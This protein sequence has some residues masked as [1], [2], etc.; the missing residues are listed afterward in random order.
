MLFLLSE[1]EVRQISVPVKSG[2]HKLR[3]DDWLD[4]EGDEG[5]LWNHHYS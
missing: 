2:R 5:G 3:E 4:G 1:G